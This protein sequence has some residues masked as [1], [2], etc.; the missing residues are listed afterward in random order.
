MV[1]T[2]KVTLTIVAIDQHTDRRKY[3]WLAIGSASHTTV[4]HTR[5]HRM[6]TC[7]GELPDPCDHYRPDQPKLRRST[8]GGQSI[9]SAIKEPTL[10][11][12]QCRHAVRVACLDSVSKDFHIRRVR[13]H[14]LQHCAAPG[15]SG[16]A[17][18]AEWPR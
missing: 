11:L 1:T 2:G 17:N 8:Y 16:P 14:S 3:I 13:G 5:C 12:E 15:K 18:S 6:T 10:S 7:I 4:R 9:L